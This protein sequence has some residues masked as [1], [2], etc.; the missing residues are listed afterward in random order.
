[1]S[2]AVITKPTK[3]QVKSK[4]R[5]NAALVFRDGNKTEAATADH[6]GDCWYVTGVDVAYTLNELYDQWVD[7]PLAL[8]Y[9]ED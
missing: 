2:L 4:Q 6:V 1:M 7:L 9:E 5:K 8:F 3:T